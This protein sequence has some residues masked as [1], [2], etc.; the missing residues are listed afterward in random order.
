[1][2][3][4]TNTVDA[5][6]DL[7]SEA[8]ED[9]DTSTVTDTDNS[10]DEAT[11]SNETETE[12]EDTSTYLPEN[13]DPSNFVSITE[14][15]AHMST[16][17]LVAAIKANQDPDPSKHYVVAQ[18]VYQT[19]KAQRDPIPHIKVK[20]EGEEQARVFIDKAKATEWWLARAERLSTRGQGGAARASSRTPEDNLRLLGE[21]AFAAAHAQAR[22]DLW[23][24]RVPQVLEKIEK[25]RGFLGDQD[26]S[27]EDVARAIQDGKDRYHA[28][29]AEKAKNR[30]RK[31]S[32]TDSE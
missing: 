11:T 6:D 16:V 10:T 28:E 20:A 2:T 27:E 32:N 26:V 7:V 1:M 25:Y 30:K 22:L 14:F 12:T 17:Q 23:Q 24:E 21:A 15:A 9:T 13:P 5:L 18:S 29:Q 3:T 4:P 8:V 31:G 19:V